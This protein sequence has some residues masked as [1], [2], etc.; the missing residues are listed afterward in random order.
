MLC[1]SEDKS[2]SWR[3]EMYQLKWQIKVWL[4]GGFVEVW[5]HSSVCF[6]LTEHVLVLVQALVAGAWEKTWR[7]KGHY[8]KISLGNECFGQKKQ[9]V[10]NLKTRTCLPVSRNHWEAEVS[11]QGPEAM[12]NIRPLRA[13]QATE[14][15]HILLWW[16]LG[17]HAGFW[18][19]KITS[20]LHF[21]LHLLKFYWNIVD[22]QSCTA[23]IITTKWF[24][25]TFTQSILFG[26]FST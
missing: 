6:L 1:W 20:D 12:R 17:S 24:S 9:L 2:F 14:F 11:V 26:F 4:D 18:A 13:L 23:E 25:Y 7:R 22:V 19:E 21:I 8:P 3:K 15:L 10:K 16:R 5:S